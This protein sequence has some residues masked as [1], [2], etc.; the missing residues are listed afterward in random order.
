[1]SSYFS[2]IYLI[3]IKT[4]YSTKECGNTGVRMQFKNRQKLI[5]RWV[6]GGVAEMDPIT[7]SRSAVEAVIDYA[8]DVNTL[9]PLQREATCTFGQGEDVFVLLPTGF[10]K[11]LCFSLLAPVFDSLLGLNQT[12]IALCVSPL[13]ALMM[14]QRSKFTMRGNRADFNF[15]KIY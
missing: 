5:E 9:K 4:L 14:E 2:V 13:T 15:N 7:R 12:S 8:V 11:S 3:I 10:G 1:M 6:V